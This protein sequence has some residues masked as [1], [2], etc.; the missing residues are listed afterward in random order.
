MKKPLM[1]IGFVS[2]M[3]SAR[4]QASTDNQYLKAAYQPATVVSVTKLN[5]SPEYYFD[6]GVQM[7]CM[8]YVGRYKSASNFVPSPIAPNDNVDVRVE[9]HWM[10]VF[11]PPNREVEMRLMSSKSSENKSCVN[12]QKS[13]T[14]IPPG[15]I[16]P[17][18]LDSTMESN[19]SQKGATIR[20]TIMQDVPLGGGIVI[21]AGSKVTGHV[22]N[23]IFPAKGTDESSLSFQ[24]DQVQL[25]HRTVPITTN[26]RALASVMEVDAARYSKTGGEGAL[27][28]AWTLVQIGG[29]QA[30]Y[31][32]DGPVTLGSQTV[33]E[34]T[35]QGVL[36][37]FTSDL[38][39]E[40]RGEVDGNNRPQAFW[41]FA[42]NAC[43]AYG[44]GDVRI[45]HSGR[46][47]PVGVV[48]LISGGK[49]LKVGKG[50]GL[51]LRVD[52]GPRGND[53]AGFAENK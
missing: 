17:L 24:F 12:E 32:Q 4:A 34:Y 7:N 40:C 6:I 52:R 47:N 19:R 13:A 20:A 42:V 15:T 44:F 36:A 39:T 46:T 14:A 8:L 35:S 26:L 21:R 16:L 23:V 43:G 50:S 25:D 18:T 22:V 45:I 51:L 41:R 9:E 10:Y 38:G 3:L 11:L 28:G 30:S 33:G 29:N 48:T 1:I 2:C 53:P 5:T 49:T 27:S 31:G 37:H